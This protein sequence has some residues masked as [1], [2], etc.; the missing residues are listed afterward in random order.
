MSTSHIILKVDDAYASNYPG[1]AEG[2]TDTVFFSGTQKYIGKKGSVKTEITLMLDSV[3]ITQ[4]LTPVDKNLNIVSVNNYG[5]YY[6]IS[7]KIE[8]LSSKNK[9]VGFM[10]LIDLMI[11]DNDAAQ[12]FFGNKEIL[13]EQSYQ[14]NDIPNEFYTVYV[15][16]NKNS[17]SSSTILNKGKATKPDFLYVGQ[18]SPFH[19]FIWNVDTDKEKFTD[20]GYLLKWDSKNLDAGSSFLYSFYYGVKSNGK[21]KALHHKKDIKDTKKIVYFPKKGSSSLTTDS[22]HTIDSLFNISNEF[23]GV[24]VEGYGDATGTDE[25]NLIVSKKRA[26]TITKYIARKGIDKSK[27]IVKPYGESGADQSDDAKKNG[28]LKDRKAVITI[29][30]E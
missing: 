11:D 18:W 10:T 5:Q 3:Y 30:Y 17:F 14:K 28:K 16:G 4:I 6:Y 22:K 21:I 27:F 24:L 7:Y 12:T 26:N 1:F 19:S 2:K 20:S 8:N 25:Q 29:Y 9:N 13:I 15:N 23:Y